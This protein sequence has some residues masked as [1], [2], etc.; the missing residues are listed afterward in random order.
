MS[1]LTGLCLICVVGIG[2]VYYHAENKHQRE[3]EARFAIAKA[4]ARP[5]W[6]HLCANYFEW[7]KAVKERVPGMEKHC[8]E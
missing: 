8:A 4:T 5:H 6:D 2:A 3:V 7:S 1:G